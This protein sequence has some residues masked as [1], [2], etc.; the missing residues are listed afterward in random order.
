MKKSPSVDQEPKQG[1]LGIKL[2]LAL[3]VILSLAMAKF[4]LVVHGFGP[5]EINLSHALSALVL[6]PL[7]LIVTTWII[8]S[9]S[10]SKTTDPQEFQLEARLVARIFWLVLALFWP[11]SGSSHFLLPT[12][13]DRSCTGSCR[14]LLC[15][16]PP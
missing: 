13:S 15:H 5:T 1:R 12:Y 16:L 14:P 11:C 8:F 4:V 2:Q 10:R 7:S 3:A 6:M 9:R